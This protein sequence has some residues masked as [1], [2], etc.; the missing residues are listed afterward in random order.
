[1][2]PDER[3]FHARMAF[4]Q[5]RQEVEVNLEIARQVVEVSLKLNLHPTKT[6]MVSIDEGFRSWEFAMFVIVT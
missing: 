3:T 1:M 2:K 4:C 5:K 6:V